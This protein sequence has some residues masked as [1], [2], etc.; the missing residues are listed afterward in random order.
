M[1]ELIA[2]IDGGG[3]HT[4]LIVADPTGEIVGVGRG[5]PINALFV[6]ELE[7][8]A[9]VTQAA[10]EATAR[11]MGLPAADA[12]RDLPLRV[13]ALYASAP[14][15]SPS[16][17]SAGIADLISPGRL[18]VEGDAPAAFA[19]AFGGG[20][21]VVVLA[22]TGS[23]AFGRA[24][25]G[26]AASTGGWGPLLGDEGG[27]YAIG[28]RA[29]RSSVL[30]W[31]GRG[32]A[33]SLCAR[34]LAHFGASEPRDLTKAGLSREAVAGFARQVSAAAHGDGD[35][36]AAGIL[37]EAGSELGLL[38]VHIARQLLPHHEGTLSVALAGGVAAAG[39]AL[40]E[41]FAH[42]ISSAD[43]RFRQAEPLYPPV[44]GALLLAAGLAGTRMDEGALASVAG[45]VHN[46]YKQ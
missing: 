24:S 42:E 33:T 46:V 29:L 37:R 14:G 7:A 19:A 38:G 36:V 23:F 2:A 10:R 43:P 15:A 21:G 20:C 1:S 35:E 5:G 16:I 34:A 30:A 25:D 12:P 13:V 11:V 45:V 18:V 27:A 44:V 6:P 26:F 17:V 40:L 32:P 8:I 3:T 22:G 9:S 39:P 4:T 28:L 41:A 31:D